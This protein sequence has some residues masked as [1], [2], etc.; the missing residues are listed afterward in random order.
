M[1]VGVGG[2]RPKGCSA[3]RRPAMALVTAVSSSFLLLLWFIVDGCCLMVF[4][5]WG[6][7]ILWGSNHPHALGGVVGSGWASQ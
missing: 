3:R 6:S 7:L 2:D 4:D 1:T 5:Y